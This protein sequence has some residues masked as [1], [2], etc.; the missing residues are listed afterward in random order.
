[1][2]I[3]NVQLPHLNPK[4]FQHK[5]SRNLYIQNNCQTKRARQ[6]CKTS[7]ITRNYLSEL[8]KQIHNPHP[9]NIV[10]ERYRIKL[11]SRLAKKSGDI[12]EKTDFRCPVRVSAPH[13]YAGNITL[14]V[15]H[16]IAES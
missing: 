7:Q 4:T 12:V 2:S 11:I 3:P 14:I 16:P 13:R 6:N 5:I 15:P 9:K 10:G 1:M 8:N